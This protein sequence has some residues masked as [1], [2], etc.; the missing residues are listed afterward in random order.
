MTEA[1]PVPDMPLED[2]VLPYGTKFE[3]DD[4]EASVNIDAA[5]DTIDG[6]VG[7]PSE[8]GFSSHVLADYNACPF[9]AYLKYVLGKAPRKRKIHFAWGSLFHACLAMKYQYGVHR[10]HEPIE[11]AIKA[12]APGMA[13]EV[14]NMVDK[15]HDLHADVELETWCPRA[16]EKNAVFW[17]EP[18]RIGG[19]RVRIP[20]SLRIDLILALKQANEACPGLGPAPQGCIV[21]DHKTSSGLTLDLVK[22]YSNDWQLKLY[23]T[24]YAR[25]LQEEFGP[26]QGI[27]INLAV[28]R[29]KLTEDHF[30]R[31]WVTLRTGVLEEFYEQEIKPTAIDFYTRLVD[32]QARNPARWPKRTLSC[33]GKWGPCDFLPM[34]DSGNLDNEIDYK[35]DESEIFW[36]KLEEKLLP[37]PKGSTVAATVDEEKEVKKE[38][39]KEVQGMVA[40]AF[41][42]SLLAWSESNTPPWD[43]LHKKRFLVEGHTDKTVRKALV[44]KIKEI[45]QPHI[46]QGTTVKQALTV[47]GTQQVELELKFAKSGMKWTYNDLKGTTT[48]KM[49]GDKI[50]DIDWFNLENL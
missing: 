25:A 40:E 1:A 37:P 36:G 48:W 30:F 4:D 49:V 47:D 45:H 35:I 10:M 22:H 9:R 41:A 42:R 19:K 5:L 7:G 24:G 27:M 20:I 34:C 15:M 12:G 28:K 16:V 11:A 26:L 2:I 44:D 6:M 31:Q 38:L 17:L 14:R 13:R 3:P 46:V 33:V 18:E 21:V 39:K 29:K 32:D 23:A 43:Q 50:C 8:G